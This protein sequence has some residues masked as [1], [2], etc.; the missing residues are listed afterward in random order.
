MSG[1]LDGT[2]LADL[3]RMHSPAPPPPARPGLSPPLLKPTLLARMLDEVLV[4]DVRDRSLADAS[5]CAARQSA[6]VPRSRLGRLTRHW[7]TETPIV[8]LASSAEHAR[9]AAHRLVE[10]GFE[11]VAAMNG[12]P[13]RLREVL[14]LD[15]W[16][17]DEH[18]RRTEL[19]A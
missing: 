11:Q 12:T 14:A 10:L 15:L 8:T 13:D 16:T 9:G 18:I 17:P 4:V 5:P 6:N 7:P 3:L 1:R 19:T 2:V